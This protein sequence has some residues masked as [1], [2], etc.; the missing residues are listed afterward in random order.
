MMI[1]QD[2]PVHCQRRKLVNKGFTPRVINTYEER[3]RAL[4]RGIL[5]TAS[6]QNSDRQS[7]A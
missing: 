1:E 2:D 7:A 6:Q 3:I 5:A 4:A